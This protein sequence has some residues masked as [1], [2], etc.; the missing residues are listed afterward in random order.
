MVTA[1]VLAGG[2]GTRLGTNV[3]KQYL[4]AGGKPVIGYCLEVLEHNEN[5][6]Q[7]L[8]VCTQQWQKFIDEWLKCLNIT[9]FSGFV[10]GG[11]SRQHSIYNALC[12]A[13]K[14]GLK[15][16]DIVLI[17]DSARPWLNDII[18]NDC[19]I[20]TQEA[21][22]ALPV[23]P[24]KDAVY[25]SR[26]GKVINGLLCRDELYA[27]Q[28]PESFKFGQYLRLNEEASDEELETVRG[29][30]EIAYNGGMNI[31][32]VKGY[33]TNYKITTM[34]DLEKFRHQLEEKRRTEL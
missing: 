25:L 13:K 16:H 15:E 9:K 19:I 17:H 20:A 28:A 33:E 10:P 14:Q 29:S 32:L 21:D 23:V 4:M 34:E 3:P 2:N 5:I 12:A 22:G 30:S 24:M 26:N 31:R 7:I 8:V 18:I 11:K 27:G 1:I 6:G